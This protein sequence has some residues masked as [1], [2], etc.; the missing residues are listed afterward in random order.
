MAA[1]EALE[2]SRGE[3]VNA[4]LAEGP[5]QAQTYPGFTRFAVSEATPDP[6]P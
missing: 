4:W 5:L 1:I 6:H 2:R 3:V